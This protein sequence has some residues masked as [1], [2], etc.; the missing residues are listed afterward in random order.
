MCHHFSVLFLGNAR[1]R[2]SLAVAGLGLGLA[3]AGPASAE[4]NQRIVGGDV[5]DP[6]DWPFIVAIASASGNNYCGGSVVAPKAVVTAAHCVEGSRP[7]SVRVI[8]GRPDLGDGSIGE[9]IRVADISVHRQYLRRGNR[10]VAVLILGRPTAALPVLLPTVAE[11]EAETAAGSELR[12]AGWGGTTPTGAHPSD[13]LRDVSLFTIS[14]AD[15]APYFSFF[16]PAE[17][18]CSFGEEQSPDRYNDSCFGDSGGPLVAYA[19]RGTLLV[20]LVSYG[21]S[22]CGVKKPGVYA[23]VATNL[24][25]I[26]RKAGLP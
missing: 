11:G 15:C 18:V 20:G 12:V 26:T 7:K 17:E 23:Q 4:P 2:V 1:G 19:P 25:F 10:D 22:L 6:A 24:G 8:A 14:D 9:K 21:G 3:L 13:V 5:A 16:R